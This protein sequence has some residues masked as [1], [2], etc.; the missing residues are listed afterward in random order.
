M[1]RSAHAERNYECRPDTAGPGPA[2]RPGAPVAYFVTFTANGALVVVP[3]A[4]LNS[5]V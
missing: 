2:K 3:A 5:T 4:L 1:I